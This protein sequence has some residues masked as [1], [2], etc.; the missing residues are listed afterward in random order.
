MNVSCWCFFYFSWF[1]SQQF[2]WTVS[3]VVP[4]WINHTYQLHLM[5]S[6]HFLTENILLAIFFAL[7]QDSHIAAVVWCRKIKLRW[8]LQQHGKA[9]RSISIVLQLDGSFAHFS[10]SSLFSLF[11][12][13][14]HHVLSPFLS[15]CPSRAHNL[16]LSLLSV[17]VFVCRNVCNQPLGRAFFSF[18]YHID[19]L[20]DFIRLIPALPPSPRLHTL[21]C[22]HSLILV[23]HTQ[24]RAHN[25]HNTHIHRGT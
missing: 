19:F 7:L 3:P 12:L 15:L 14:A 5:I 20:Y 16:S 22:S 23:T 13:I 1:C 21:S 18:Q 4:S 25:T 10:L 2:T 6:P 17:S 8:I 24:M 11:W 9:S